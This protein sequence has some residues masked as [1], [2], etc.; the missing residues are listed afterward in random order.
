V[1]HFG[2]TVGYVELWPGARYQGGLAEGTDLQLYARSITTP[3]SSYEDRTSSRATIRIGGGGIPIQGQR[4]S[5]FPFRQG[6]L[7][8]QG[9]NANPQPDAPMRRAIDI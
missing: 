7:T 1:H 6:R 2:G 9:G 5:E 8:M 3:K 4:A